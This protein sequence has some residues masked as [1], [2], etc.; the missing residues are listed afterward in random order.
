MRAMQRA[1][2]GFWKHGY[3]LVAWLIA[4]AGIAVFWSHATP[5]LCYDKYWLSGD[6]GLA[7]FNSWQ[8][9]D[10]H[11]LYRD[12]FEYRTPLFFVVIGA[13]LRLTGP[14]AAAAQIATILIVSAVAPVVAVVVRRLG[15]SRLLGCAAGIMP[16]LASF[17]VWPFP[18]PPWLLWLFVV[19]AGWALERALRTEGRF[20]RGWLA[21]AGMFTGC[22]I[23]TIQS[24]GAPFAAGMTVALA[25][26]LPKGQRLRGVL[27]FVASGALIALPFVIHYAHLGALGQAFWDT[28][29]WPRKYYYSGAIPGHYPLAGLAMYLHKRGVCSTMGAPPVNALY[30]AS[31]AAIPLQALVAFFASLAVIVHAFVRRRA[32]LDA[33]RRTL[34]VLC[35]GGAAAMAPELCVPAL[36]DLM[37]IGMAQVGLAIPLAAIAASWRSRLGRGVMKGF[38]YVLTTILLLVALHRHLERKPFA[39]RYRDYDAFVA[40]YA[41][42]QWVGELSEP[43]DAVVNIPYGG[44]QLFS[45]QRQN[46][47]SWSFVFDDDKLIPRVAWE[48]MV[49]DLQQRK[50]TILHFDQKGLERRF[51]RLDPGLKDRYFWN[52]LGWELRGLPHVTLATTYT[53]GTGP[54]Q[55]DRLTVTQR[56]QELVATRSHGARTLEL[57]GSVRTT[58]VHLTGPGGRLLVHQQAD[59][60]LR[61]LCAGKPCTLTPEGTMH[62]SVTP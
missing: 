5:H 4:L 30:T 8:V 34:I 57:Q 44:W 9:A 62:P 15:G 45:M 18:L 11:E 37:H 59:G 26:I 24:S 54:W 14:S 33:S 50:P 48:Q 32:G 56:G 51:F 46:G 38:I 47:L 35:A 60:S 22:V 19:L 31:V 39:R 16:V 28:M 58:R 12:I 17:A 6:S 25:C 55:G 27:W 13:L 3:W 7:V 53:V 1:A 49:K 10:G 20:D 40:S 43:G 42:S 29:T 2:R 21:R 23:M 52:G 61:G 41:G 36:S